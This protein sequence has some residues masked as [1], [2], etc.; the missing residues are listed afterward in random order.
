VQHLSRIDGCGSMLPGEFVTPG[1]HACVIVEGVVGRK[2]LTLCLV[3]RMRAP[4]GG[5]ISSR[6]RACVVPI[7]ASVCAAVRPGNRYV[8][9]DTLSLDSHPN[10]AGCFLTRIIPWPKDRPVRR[11][12]APAA[13]RQANSTSFAVI[14]V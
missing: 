9:S 10:Y 5:V 3:G 1:W 7:R 12:V 2:A 13:N 8:L 4:H 14:S 6:P 11:F